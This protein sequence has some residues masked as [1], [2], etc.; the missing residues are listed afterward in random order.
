MASKAFC[1]FGVFKR[2]YSTSIAEQWI[3]KA[4]IKIMVTGIATTQKSLLNIAV[5]QKSRYVA[6]AIDPTR[7]AKLNILGIAFF[8]TAK[9][10]LHNASRCRKYVVQPLRYHNNGIYLIRSPIQIVKQLLC[11]FKTKIGSS[12][13]VIILTL[14]NSSNFYKLCVIIVG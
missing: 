7:A 10:I 9:P 14:T 4:F 6:H 8:R 1:T 5:L 11:G 3:I 13:I 2:S 12:K